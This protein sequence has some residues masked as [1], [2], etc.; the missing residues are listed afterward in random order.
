M[1]S[2]TPP[3]TITA[4]TAT[5]IAEPVPKV[6]PPERVAALVEVPSGDTG[7]VAGAGLVVGVA[8]GF[9][10]TPG[11]NGELPGGLS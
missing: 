7:V 9:C 5:A 2:E 6:P 8:L 11:E 1:K 4:P 10:G 3:S